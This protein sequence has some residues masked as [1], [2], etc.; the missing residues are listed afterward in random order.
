MYNS[1]IGNKSADEQA[2]ACPFGCSDGCYKTCEA[3]CKGTCEIFNGTTA[4]DDSKTE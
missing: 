4:V 2:R 3:G 1:K